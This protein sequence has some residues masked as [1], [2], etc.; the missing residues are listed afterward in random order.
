MLKGS[1]LCGTVRYEI[2]AQLGKIGHCHCTQCQKAHGAAFGTYARVDKRAFKFSAGENEV[3][4]YRSSKNATR[5]F[6]G[7]CGSTLQFIDNKTP[8]L[9]IALA[10]L[11]DPIDE[12]VT[13]EIWCQEKVSW[14][15]HGMTID[16]YDI[17]G[18]ND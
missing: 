16:S 4:L 9:D 7:I 14:W 18:P 17:H 8:Y 3:G 13:I 12:K 15:D 2:S 11:D 1:C 5:T 10:T 6:C